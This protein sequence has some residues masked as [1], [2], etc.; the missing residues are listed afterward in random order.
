MIDE[1][2]S[3]ADDVAA[4]VA[5][6]SAQPEAR[7]DGRNNLGQ[8]A[9]KTPAAEPA[10]GA[11]PAPPAA[12]AGTP[13]PT[14]APGAAATPPGGDPAATPPGGDP[15]A[16]TL[17]PS[18]PP[19]GWKAETKAKWG[20]IPE[21]IRAEIIR[22][23]EDSARGVE[24]MRKYFEP[25][26]EVYSE[27][28]KNAQYF[29]HIQRNPKDYISEVIQMEQTL[30]LGNPAQKLETILAVGDRYGVPLRQIMDASMNGQLNQVLQNAHTVHRTPPPVPPHI[31]RELEQLRGIASAAEISAAE[32]QFNDF[33]ATGP[34][35][36][37]EV[38]EEMEK[39][40]ASEVVSTYKDAYDL[41]VWRN[42]DLRARAAAASNGSAMA[43]GA[44]Q[45]QAA[46]AAIS[47]PPSAPVVPPGSGGQQEESIEDAVRRAF[48]SHATPGGV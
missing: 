37:N 32:K 31:A 10:S 22:R 24:R 14:G 3:V 35:F 34:E 5:A 12:D 41:A 25:M 15:A 1:N 46:A 36:F 26:E 9:P 27:V 29:Q 19:Q 48:R 11:P 17:D 13:P 28:A 21:D 39:L 42:P 33:M 40:L 45:R 23:E 2:G 47:T 20:E 8:Y 4:A 16:L 38:G 7:D 6:A 43:S 30:T 44:A 18:K